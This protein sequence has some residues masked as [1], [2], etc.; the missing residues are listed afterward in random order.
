MQ[1]VA[2]NTNDEAGD[3]TTT[4]T[5]LARS[6]ARDGFEVVSKG[7][8]PIAVRRG[9]CHALVQVYSTIQHTYSIHRVY[10]T[11]VHHTVQHTYSTVYIEYDRG[12]TVDLLCENSTMSY[13]C[14]DHGK[15]QVSQ[16]F[17]TF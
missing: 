17:Q 7:A 3:G 14:A 12:V 9:K 10:S 11:G 1:D 15:L 4:A 13:I 2:N 16:S 6:I 8:N 5:V